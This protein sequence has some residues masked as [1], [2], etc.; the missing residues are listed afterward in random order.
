MSEQLAA[1]AAA[2]GTPEELVERAA[3]ARATAQGR[4]YEEIIAAWA[5]GESATVAVTPETS[6]AAD[7]PTEPE[8][9]PES[10][11]PS[12]AATA[13]PAVP[14]APTPETSV[15]VMEQPAGA[16][17]LK[18]KRESFA[19]LL[20]GILAL[21]AAA[22]LLVVVIPA[23]SQ[24]DARHIVGEA[25]LS[26][27]EDRGRDVYLQQGCQYCHTQNVRSVVADVGLGAITEPGA[28][29]L[30]SPAT[31]GFQRI[32]PDLAHVASR[33]PEDVDGAEYLRDFLIHPT[34]IVEGSAQPPYANL[35]EDDMDALVAYVLA[36]R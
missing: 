9:K 26:A 18:A 20:T 4:S 31:F 36:L 6:P 14:P 29:S 24:G 28:R 3:I 13:A 21:L 22:I 2:M 8:S 16:P 5:G 34:E 32:G 17:L 11:P 15:A 10:D 33:L 27:L 7:P 25:A 23:N 35:S 1:A 30:A 12:E 19:G